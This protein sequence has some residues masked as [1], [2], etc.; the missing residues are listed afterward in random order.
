M[1]IS[2]LITLHP[3]KK[4]M[5]HIET[6]NNPFFELLITKF[7]RKSF[8]IKLYSEINNVSNPPKVKYEVIAHSTNESVSGFGNNPGNAFAEAISKIGYDRKE[9][10]L[11]ELQSHYHVT[12]NFHKIGGL[13]FNKVVRKSLS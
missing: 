12:G 10:A 6:E 4:K 11:P 7:G 1:L 2:N 9:R 8:T 5:T 3:Q 13:E